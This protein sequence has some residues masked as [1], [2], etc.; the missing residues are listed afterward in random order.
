MLK[1]FTSLDMA[2]IRTWNDLSQAFL[3][4]YSFNLDLVPKRAD[5]VATKQ[6]PSEPFGEYVGRWRTLTSQVRDGP[7][8]EESLEIVIGGA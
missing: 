2:T 3:G 8:N 5:L 4:Q 6:N 7:Y 1:W